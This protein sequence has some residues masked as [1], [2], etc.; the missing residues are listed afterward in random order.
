MFEWSTWR[1]D[2]WRMGVAQGDWKKASRML[3][4]LVI[5]AVNVVGARMLYDKALDWALGNEDEDD[6][7]IYERL[8]R[9][10]LGKHPVFGDVF[11]GIEYDSI[12]LGPVDVTQTA[13]RGVSQMLH[14]SSPESKIRGAVQV[15][16]S[17]GTLGGFGGSSQFEKILND[18][19][20]ISEEQE[21]ERNRGV[22]GS[23]NSR[24]DA[25][26]RNFK[27]RQDSRRPDINSFN[28]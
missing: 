13:F 19:L 3:P 21:R 25:L 14:G 10:F 12:F 24:I 4:A 8:V 6:R 27:D 11:T 16:G 17:A 22:G 7:D 23:G 9:E 26:H 1:N 28:R 18:F 20:K 2:F 5:A 15:A